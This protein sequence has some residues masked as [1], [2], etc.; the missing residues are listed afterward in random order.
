M[1]SWLSPN[2][3]RPQETGR[4]AALKEL[5]NAVDPA[6]FQGAEVNLCDPRAG[7]ALVRASP[8]C[9]DGDASNTPGLQL[10]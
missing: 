5:E 7:R 4:S 3:L 6:I 9:V 2:R 1:N 8:F 10:H